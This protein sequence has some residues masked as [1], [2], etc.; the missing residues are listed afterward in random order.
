MLLIQLMISL[1]LLPQYA[2]SQPEPCQQDQ[3]RPDARHQSAENLQVKRAF[4]FADV[5]QGTPNRTRCEPGKRLHKKQ[6]G[7]ISGHV[8]QFGHLEQHGRA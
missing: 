5:E 8:S 4:R 7:E 6:Y 1:D 3:S 2:F